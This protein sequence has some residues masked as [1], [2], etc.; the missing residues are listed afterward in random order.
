MAAR[1]ASRSTSSGNADERRDEPRLLHRPRGLDR[2]G[3]SEQQEQLRADA[4][5]RKLRQPRLLRD[6]GVEPFG[7]GRG[8][9][10][11]AGEEA[12]EAEDAQIVLADALPCIADEAHAPSGEVRVS[13]ERILH[14]AVGSAVERV[15]REVAPT[16]VLAPVVGEGHARVAAE[17]LDVAAQRRHLDRHMLGDDRHGA[18]LDARRNGVEAGSRGKPH[19]V[20]RQRRRRHVDVLDRQAHQRIAHRAADDARLR[21]LSLERCEHLGRRGPVEPLG[22]REAGNAALFRARHRCPAAN[23]GGPARCGRP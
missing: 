8:C 12:E 19:H 16:G 6:R 14:R 18:M 15:H 23:R 3:R 10:I 20:G 17:G 7:V 13:A 4:L 22:L 11:V 5:A 2:A 1:R 21:S 9:R